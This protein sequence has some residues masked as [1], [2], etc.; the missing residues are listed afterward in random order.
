MEKLDYKLSKI[1]KD[2]LEID[3]NSNSKLASEHFWGE[4]MNLNVSD[5]LYIYFDIETA[6]NIKIS[7]SFILERKFYNYRNILEYVN[8]EIGTK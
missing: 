6:F 4:K 1:F 8:S 3:I 5:I 2:R 7:D